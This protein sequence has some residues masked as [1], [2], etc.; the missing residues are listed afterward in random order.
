AAELTNFSLAQQEQVLVE[1]QD[2]RDEIS[3]VSLDE[4]VTD[5]IRLQSSYQANARVIST[6]NEMLAQLVA[7]I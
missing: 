5:L 7:I 4:E 1:V 2:R 3:G 6:V